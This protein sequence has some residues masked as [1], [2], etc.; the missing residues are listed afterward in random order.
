M[1]GTGIEAL[2]RLQSQSLPKFSIAKPDL[3]TEPLGRT[4]DVARSKRAKE[5]CKC[6]LE[7]RVAIGTL[8]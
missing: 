8:K 5:A 1:L 7:G 3:S 6:A 2:F 4:E